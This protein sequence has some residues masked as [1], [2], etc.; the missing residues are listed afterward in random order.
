MDF[1]NNVFINCPFDKEYKPILKTIFFGLVYL[2]YQ[3][4]LSETKNSAESRLD[5]IKN[6]IQQAKY[7]IHDLS[8]ME[9]T[10]SSDLSRFNMPFEL[11][12]DIGC[13]YFGGKLH[14]TKCLLVLDKERYRYQKA[15][16]DLSGNDIG[17]HFNN[18]E[19]ALREIRNWIRKV[20]KSHIPSATKIWLKS[21]DFFSYL[22]NYISIAE[23][24]GQRD[25]E[26]MGWSELSFYI[27]QW[28]ALE[29]VD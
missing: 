14:T 29:S 24:L 1:E 11:G 3:P 4:L 17:A 18:P 12:I 25:I 10:G 15:I 6:L 5:Q 27:K 21:N 20:K 8:R 7:S 9:L 19:Q 2:G 13:R 26:E 28:M 23:N 16:S 22:N